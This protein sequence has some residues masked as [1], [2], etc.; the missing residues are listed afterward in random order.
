MRR[1][2]DDVTSGDEVLDTFG[3]GLAD[4]AAIAITQ[5]QQRGVTYVTAVGNNEGKLTTPAFG[6]EAAPSAIKVAALN[7]L[8][9]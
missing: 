1:I 5:V 3:I 6:H 7:W 2:V 9:N 4:P 8:A